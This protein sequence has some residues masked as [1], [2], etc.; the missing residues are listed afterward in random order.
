[1]TLRR[2]FRRLEAPGGVAAER[3]QAEARPEIVARP[4]EAVIRKKT[5]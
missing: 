2:T 3:L 4:G 1:L 5:K